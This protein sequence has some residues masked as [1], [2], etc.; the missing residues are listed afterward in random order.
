MKWRKFVINA[1]YD[2]TLYSGVLTCDAIRNASLGLV[3]TNTGSCRGMLRGRR[4]ALRSS[5]REIKRMI[6]MET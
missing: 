1:Y 2:S 3:S 6:I 5:R 4:G